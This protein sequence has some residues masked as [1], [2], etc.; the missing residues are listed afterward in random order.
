MYVDIN[1]IMST[2]IPRQSQIC[3]NP[4]LSANSAPQLVLVVQMWFPNTY[5]QGSTVC[6]WNH[7]SEEQRF[8]TLLPE[9]IT[10]ITSSSS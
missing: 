4:R 3:P 5:T 1:R 8:G 6:E 7:L 10:I 2:E 9:F